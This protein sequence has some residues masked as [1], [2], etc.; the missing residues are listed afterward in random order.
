MSVDL[1]YPEN[2]DGNAPFMRI[3]A[4]KADYG[5][6]GETFGTVTL[7]HPQQVSFADGASFS[8]F[9]MGPLGSNILEGMKNGESAGEIASR[10][11][12]S[13]FG[14]S[15]DPE[16]STM[17][18]M[19]IA[20]NS[21]AGAIVPGADQLQNIYGQSKGKAVNPNT[22]TAFQNMVLRSFAF[23]FKLVAEN[24]F[25]ADE[26]RNI[27]RF[28]RATMYAESGQGNYLL[29]YP[30]VFAIEFCTKE[31]KPNPYYPT[32]YQTNLVNFTTNFSAPTSMHF[33]GGA[34]L[35]VD[36]S[37]TFQETKVLTLND[38]N[39]ADIALI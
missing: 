22:V 5:S 23:N 20:Q 12:E 4:S 31:G 8:T 15:A 34:P 7:Y 27:Q 37:L 38:F 18:A 30:H 3:T 2:L 10:M 13:A 11:N 28:F 39:E 17:L 24:P 19:K 36:M 26:I 21:G 32:I 14:G 16:L 9:D 25:E 33:E 29:T 1:I 6:G 35:E